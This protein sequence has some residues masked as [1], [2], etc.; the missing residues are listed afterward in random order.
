M[1]RECF[2]WYKLCTPS[3]EIL[4]IPFSDSSLTVGPGMGAFVL[5]IMLEQSN[6]NVSIRKI[7]ELLVINLYLL[8][9]Q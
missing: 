5:F 3:N 4:T 9:I 2:K 8:V 7:I 6:E 1:I